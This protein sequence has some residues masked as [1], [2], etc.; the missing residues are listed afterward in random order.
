MHCTE[1][2]LDQSSRGYSYHAFWQAVDE[3]STDKSLIKKSGLERAP[4]GALQ[5][6]K[7]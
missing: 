4:R 6:A 2:S 7:H 1:G 5:V 3:P